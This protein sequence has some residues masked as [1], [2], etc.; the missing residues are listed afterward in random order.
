MF[1]ETVACCTKRII[2]KARFPILKYGESALCKNNICQGSIT[3]NDVNL[4]NM[5]VA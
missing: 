4:Q 5:Y 3:F 1:D 2:V